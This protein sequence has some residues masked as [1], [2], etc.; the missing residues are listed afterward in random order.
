MKIHTKIFGLIKL[1]LVLALPS[2]AG[3]A[4]II[5]Y[6]YQATSW[7]IEEDLALEISTF[8][9]DYGSD[10][11]HIPFLF[12]ESHTADHVLFQVYIRNVQDEI[13]NSSKGI[14]SCIIQAFSYQFKG[15]DPV[16][17]IDENAPVRAASW[18]QSED[19]LPYVPDEEVEVRIRFKLNGKEHTREG[20]MK[21]KREPGKTAPLLINAL[22]AT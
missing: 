4:R 15:E 13:Y 5:V 11:T 17:L 3:C 20:T 22:W 10:G 1:G 14:D 21:A 12:L 16:I 7:S 8:P 2:L 19:P 9:A 6:E 18:Q